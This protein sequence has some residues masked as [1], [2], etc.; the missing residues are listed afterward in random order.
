MAR[1]Q[2]DTESG[3]RYLIDTDLKVMRRMPRAT[4]HS[5]DP[6]VFVSALRGDN[7]DLPFVS[8]K[9]ELGQP[10]YALWNDH[11]RPNWRISTLVTAVEEIDVPSAPD[12]PA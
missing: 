7:D 10:L 6:M 11:G 8:I 3:S 9:F 1:Y 12:Q 2:V 5:G 4:E